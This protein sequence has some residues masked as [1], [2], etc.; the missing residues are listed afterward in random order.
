MATSGRRRTSDYNASSGAR[1]PEVVEENWIERQ[2][3]DCRRVRSTP[4]LLLPDGAAFQ[5]GNSSYPFDT[6]WSL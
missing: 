5:L 1:V 6:S 3:S 4:L 2:P